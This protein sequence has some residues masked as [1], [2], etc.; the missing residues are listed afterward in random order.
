MIAL[1]ITPPKSAAAPITVPIST[2]SITAKIALNDF[3]IKNFVRKKTAR[4]QNDRRPDRPDKVKDH[5]RH[6]VPF[7]KTVQGEHQ[8]EKQNDA[9]GRRQNKSDYS[10]YYIHCV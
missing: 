3:P 9:A 1:T 10:R 4:A 5:R 6:R 8:K 2:E 7:G